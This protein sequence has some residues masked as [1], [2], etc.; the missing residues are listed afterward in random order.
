MKKVVFVLSLSI[1]AVAA[2]YFISGPANQPQESYSE[3]L[4]EE[5]EA[6]ARYTEMRA[7]YDFDM[8][9]DP[10]TG[11]VPYGIRA[12]EISFAR[13]IPE[14]GA[15]AN[16]L[17]RPTAL[18]TYFPAGPNNQGGRTRGLAYDVRFNGSTN[19]VILAGG[20]S[21]G[22]FRSVNAGANWTR[23]SPEGDIHNVSCIVQDPRP[24]N[25]DTW[26]AGGGEPF[27]NSTTELG[28]PYHSQGLFKSTDNGATWTRLPLNNITDINGS[29]ILPSGTLEGFDHP[30][31][32]VHKIAVNPVNGDVYVAAHR[33]LCR[34]TNGGTTFNVVFTSTAS[35]VITANSINGQCDVAITNTGKVMLAVNGGNPD[36]ALRGV[37]TS[38][39]G[40]ASSF[41]RIAGG[42]TLGVDSVAN[43]RANSFVPVTGTNPVQFVAKRILLALAPS[44]Q[45][46]CYVM[47]E[48]GLSN[49]APDNAPEADLFRLDM[50]SGNSWSNRSANMPDFPGGNIPVTDPFAVQG[51]YDMHIAIKPTDPN[52]VLIGGTSLYRSTDG[53]ASTAA[54]SWIGGYG[55]TIPNATF[56]PGSHPDMHHFVFNP[57]NPN[58]GIS[59]NDG[60]LQRTTDINAPNSTVAWTNLTNYQT[61]QYYYVAID[62][63]DGRNNFTGGSQDNGT[64]FRDKTGQL[65]TAPAD[66]NNHRQILINDGT[67]VGISR[68]NGSEQFAYAGFQ[69][70]RIRRIRLQASPTSTD[71]RPTGLTQTPGG[72]SQEFGEFITNF[73][74]NNDNTED[75]YYVNFARL[76]R[77][78]NASTVT[79]GGWTELTGVSSAISPLNPNATNVGIRALAFSRGPYATS[80]ALYI[81]TTNARIFRLDNPR[82]AAP[83]TAPFDI[84]P[85]GI[86]A[87]SNVQDIAVNPNNDDEVIAIVSNYNVT[88]IWW[89]NNAKSATPT[90]RNAEGNLTLPSV[91][92]CM[93]TVKKDASNNPVT[94]YYI[95]TSVGLFSASDI[96]VPLLASQPVTWQRE[97]GN[98]LNFAVIQSMAYRPGDNVLLV[99]THGNGLYYTFLGTPN[100]NPN[101]NTGTGGPAI[102]DKNF[103]K[104]VFPTAG[105]GIVNYRIGNML[106]VKRIS[107][108][109]YNVSG[110]VVFQRESSYQDG[111]VDLAKFAPGTYILS[112]YSD[113]GKYRH[114]QKLVRQ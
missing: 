81:G 44:N 55:N 43:W 107:V 14:R 75:L 42:S 5:E 11:K 12:Q 21:G 54:T 10:A 59:G 105:N 49:V 83:A 29:T 77:T 99:G 86:S 2:W 61:L 66:S 72:S 113:D 64:Q 82:N 101:Q 91:R 33:R 108:Q 7:Q 112:I 8:L 76:F 60:G 56:Y 98:V 19:Q 103:I 104:T 57:A 36:F 24:G 6:E 74:L 37:W 30:F 23:V 13:A 31:D 25:Q 26:Y 40:N 32:Y 46:I 68:L 18:N 110:Q 67:A 102:N 71:I 78:T 17:A 53:F 87:G 96:S 4:E 65:G 52:F 85:P 50:T 93:I 28:A 38:N 73:R 39:S 95:G 88:S 62:P 47:Y 34:S 69:L 97:G 92:S 45:N 22:I 35:P 41:T 3:A 70:G 63:G 48:N 109:L 1:L 51:G 58:E 20:V 90:W 9:K 80:H 16:I 111:A 89:T 15:N 100:F 84:T 114:L 106:T 27:G 94:E 79:T